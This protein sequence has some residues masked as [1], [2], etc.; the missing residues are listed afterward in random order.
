[1]LNANKIDVAMHFSK[2]IYH[3]LWLFS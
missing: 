1:M 2:M 3:F